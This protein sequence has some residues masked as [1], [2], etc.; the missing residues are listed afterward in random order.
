MAEHCVSFISWLPDLA[1][2]SM[3]LVHMKRL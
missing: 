2:A 1:G 3:S